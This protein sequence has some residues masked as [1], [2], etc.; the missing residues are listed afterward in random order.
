MSPKHYMGWSG[1][2][3]ACEND[4]R[5]MAAL[6][7]SLGYG[8]NT[9]LLTQAAT[10]RKVVA[11][12]T[13]AA[14]SMT[15]KDAFLLT[16]SG[17][18]GQVTDTNGDEAHRDYGEIG[19]TADTK[20]ET[21]CLYDRQLID[22]ELWALWA[23]FPAGSRIFVL[24]DSCHS[25]TIPR[26][27][28]WDLLATVAAGGGIPRAAVPAGRAMPRAVADKVQKGRAAT[29][30][31]IQRAVPARETS[32]VTATVA[33]VSGCQDNQT[34][35][36]GDRNGL[37]TENLLKVWDN[38]AFVGSLHDLRNQVAQQMPPYQSPNYYVV[39]RRNVS[40]LRRPALRV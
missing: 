11:A 15:S 39:G 5:D 4:A 36:D 9:L 2:L 25:G 3:V 16:Y 28:N 12:I 17:H 23:E 33:L 13:G 18:G 14:K 21:W 32:G 34:S 35:L 27:P 10:S 19:G 7:T 29:Y 26:E 37:F 31:R 8:P 38:G 22:D 30:A 40:A 20:D 24:S 6:A 1:D